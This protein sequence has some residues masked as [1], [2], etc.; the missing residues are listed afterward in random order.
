MLTRALANVEVLAADLPR[1]RPAYRLD[2][3]ALPGVVSVERVLLEDAQ[4]FIIR[5]EG[6]YILPHL[7]RELSTLGVTRISSKEPTLED[8]YVQ[9]LG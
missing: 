4:R 2:L 9:L 6:A 1:G 3:E 7:L 5:A 8:V